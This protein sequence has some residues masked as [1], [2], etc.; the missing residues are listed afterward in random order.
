MTLISAIASL[1]FC[2]P[3]RCILRLFSQTHYKFSSKDAVDLSC[4]GYLPEDGNVTDGALIILHGLLS[5]Q[6]CISLNHRVYLQILKWF[7]T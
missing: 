4:T 5:V 1:R 7:E 6:L 3:Q 2:K